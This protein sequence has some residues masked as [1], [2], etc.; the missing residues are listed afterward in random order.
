MEKLERVSMKQYG[1]GIVSTDGMI[2]GV[3]A[4][5][6]EVADSGAEHHKQGE[7]DWNKEKRGFR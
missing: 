4:P 6:M 2:E 5:G 1:F 3:P 7:S